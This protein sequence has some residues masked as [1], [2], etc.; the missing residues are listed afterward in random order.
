MIL[1]RFLRIENIISVTFLMV[2]LSLVKTNMAHEN[3]SE[4]KPET[5]IIVNKGAITGVVHFPKEY[6]EREKITITKNQ[7]VCGTFLYSETF[8]VSKENQGL[9]N[10][11]ISLANVKSG[12]KNSAETASINQKGCRYVPHV[13]AVTVGTVLEILNS[14]GIL[15]NIHAYFGSLEPSNTVFNKAQ[16]KFLKRINQTLDKPGIYYFK[17]DVHSHMTAFI[18]VMEHPYYAVTDET[19]KFTI[20]D[21]PPG[22]YTVHAWH[23]ALGTLEKEVTV[24]ADKT[25]E[26]SFEI[27]PPNK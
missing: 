17:C 24:E 26:V 19:G 23:E 22:K 16:P 25:A 1:K 6:P 12:N 8:V 10:V 13:Q 2:L 15:H 4:R 3:F 20:T 7:K 11:V 5:E 27:F 9:Q 21:I 14:D 18:V